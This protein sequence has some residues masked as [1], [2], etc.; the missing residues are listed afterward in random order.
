MA[1]GLFTLIAALA[2]LV[3]ACDKPKPAWQYPTPSPATRPAAVPSP[4]VLTLATEADVA[5]AAKAASDPAISKAVAEYLG[6]GAPRWQI[7][8]ARDVGE[9]VLLW[10]GF[11]KVADGGIDLVYSKLD[12][13]VKWQFRGAERG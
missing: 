7:F 5:A 13:R 6:P 2:L 4:D 9:C 11:P 1:R 10:V 3:G 12:R 8:A